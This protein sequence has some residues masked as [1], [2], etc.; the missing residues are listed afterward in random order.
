MPP[1]PPPLEKSLLQDTSKSITIIALYNIAT[2]HFVLILP[3]T[4]NLSHSWFTDTYY[5]SSIS[6]VLF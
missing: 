6:F 2:Y 5:H 3:F 4:Q 1:L